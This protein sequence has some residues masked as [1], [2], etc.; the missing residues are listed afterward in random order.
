MTTQDPKSNRASGS[1]TEAATAERRGRRLSLSCRLFF[2]GEDDFE[3]EATI[4]DLST[5]GC[6]ATSLTE[7][8]IGTTLRLSLFLQ[9]QQWPVRIDGAMVRWVHGTSFGLEFTEIR[10]AQRER[11]RAVIMKAKL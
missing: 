3:G 9:D 5:G 6:Q 2:F 10:S 11:I 4:L 7:L 1:D 8:Q